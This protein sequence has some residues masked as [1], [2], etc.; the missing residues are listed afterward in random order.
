MLYL[1]RWVVVGH[2]VSAHL[3]RAFG[4]VVH[5]GRVVADQAFEVRGSP[6]GACEA[7]AHVKLEFADPTRF[8]RGLRSGPDGIG[9]RLEIRAGF[10]NGGGLLPLPAFEESMVVLE[11]QHPLF[12]RGPER[13]LRAQGGVVRA[14]A[15]TR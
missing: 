13:S 10:V 1:T 12:D 11:V 15:V 8:A 3:H 14:R 7:L 5:R 6:V 9:V 2:D 4:G